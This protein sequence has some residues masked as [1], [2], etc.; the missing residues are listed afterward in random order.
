MLSTDTHEIEA[1]GKQVAPFVFLI[2]RL[3]LAPSMRLPDLL[4]VLLREVPA[5]GSGLA[6]GLAHGA[7]RFRLCPKPAPLLS[8]RARLQRPSLQ[9]TQKLS[10]RLSGD[11]L[12]LR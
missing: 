6:P 3:P 11:C 9:I 12:A 1:Q 4:L 7:L 8:H 5:W 10:S 2:Q